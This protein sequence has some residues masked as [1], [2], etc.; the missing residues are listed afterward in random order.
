MP[1]SVHAENVSM[2]VLIGKRVL[3]YIYAVQCPKTHEA[4]SCSV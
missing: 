2:E 1:G 4:A 3:V